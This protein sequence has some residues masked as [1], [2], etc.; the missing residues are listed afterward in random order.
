MGITDALRAIVDPDMPKKKQPCGFR[1]LSTSL[2][3]PLT[4]PIRTERKPRKQY[5]TKY[6]DV[7]SVRTY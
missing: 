1:N 3:Q 4:A 6:R 5:L 7:P 2:W